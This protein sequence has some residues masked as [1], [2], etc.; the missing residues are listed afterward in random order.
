MEL[1]VIIPCYNGEDTLSNQLSA[2]ENQQWDAPWEV[3]VVDNRST[4]D[5]RAVVRQFQERMPNLRLVDGF[6][7]QGQPYALNTG[8][9]AAR[10]DAVAFCDVDDVVGEGWVAAMGEALKRH[11]FV[12]AR[13]DF[14]KLNPPWTVKYRPN[15]QNK[16]IQ[17][18]NNPPYL[19]HA[20]GGSLGVKRHIFE[21]AGGF[22][23]AFPALH[24]T[25]FCWKVQRLGVPLVFVPE[26]VLHVR[27]RDTL[28]GLFK[29]AMAYGEFN[30]KLYAKYHRLDMPKLSWRPGARSWKRILRGL[31]RWRH[32]ELRP[33]VVRGLGW[34][35]GRFK[36]CI[37]YRTTAL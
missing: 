12:A 30:V 16:G 6:G 34:R 14:E 2:L 13:F 9:A 19:P 10:S 21:R 1:S 28:D 24:D 23:D 36:G 20:G 37:K 15:P 27:L 26:A 11:D 3:V 7:Q 5:S 17:Q 4:D 29:Q 22:D 35:L 25:D 18:Y 33:Q 32:P 8:V 31:P